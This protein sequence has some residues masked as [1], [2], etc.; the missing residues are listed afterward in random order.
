MISSKWYIIYFFFKELLQ[1]VG[2]G[3]GK[4]LPGVDHATGLRTKLDLKM[5]DSQEYERR[6]PS[7]WINDIGENDKYHAGGKALR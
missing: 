5:F 7:E 1:K 6:T 3:Y 2:I 4:Y